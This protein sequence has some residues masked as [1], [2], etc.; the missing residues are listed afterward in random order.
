MADKERHKCLPVFTQIDGH[1]LE[2]LVSIIRW[3]FF[4]TDPQISVSDLNLNINGGN[5]LYSHIYGRFV[6]VVVLLF[7]AHGKH[8]MRSCRDG[9]LI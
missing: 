3:H 2:V 7:Y 5:R 8:P 9:Q 4:P 1:M 6:V